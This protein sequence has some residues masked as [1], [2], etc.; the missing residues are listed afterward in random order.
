MMD[1]SSQGSTD[2]KGFDRIL[3][4][5]D[6]I[7]AFAITLL[8]LN[9]AVPTLKAGTT[10]ADLLSSLGKEY[11]TFVAYAISFFV[12]NYYWLAHHRI[13][14][15]IKKYDNRLIQ[16]NTFFLLFITLVP[17]FT[18]LISQY[19]NLESA[20]VLYYISQALGGSILTILWI[21][22]SQGFLLISKDTPE[23][24]IRWITVRNLVPPV[25]FLGATV[26]SLFVPRY[27]FLSLFAIGFAIRILFRRYGVKE[28]RQVQTKG[29]SESSKAT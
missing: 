14:R 8:V 23:N 2:D 24:L 18:E 10:S 3:A 4:L 26:L 21:Y 6:G 27:S 28:N 7:F 19:G 16:L 9:L 29:S 12:I 25:V 17:F 15:Y 1:E 22:A 11:S 5:S 13:F 20:D